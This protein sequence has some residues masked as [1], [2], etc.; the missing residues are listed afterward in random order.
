ML[1]HDL[2]K[3]YHTKTD[4]EL[5]QLAMDSEQLTLEAQAALRSELARRRID[6]AEHRKVQEERNQDRIEPP[7]TRGMLLLP[8]S[9]GVGEFVAEVL[10]VYHG[11]FLFFVKLTAPA[12]VVGYIAV[13]MGRNE[14]REIARHLPRGVEMLGHKTEI[15]EMWFANFAGYF[16]SWMAFCFS[17]GA[18]CAAV[19]QI[20]DGVIPSVRDCFA[21]IRERMSSFLQLSLLL[22]F[23]LFAIEVGA[24]LL[25]SGVFWVLHQ[26]HAHLSSFTIQFLSF[27][28]AGLGLLVFSRFGLGIPALVLGNCRVG[29][30]MFRSDELTE[31]K[32]LTLAVLLTKSLIGGYFT[33]MAPFWLASFIPANI[34]L[35]TWFPWVL[36]VASIAGV[37]VVEPTMFIGFALLYS[38]MSTLSAA[39]SELLAQQSM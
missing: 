34:E 35:P 30:A 37:T 2:A 24:V 8:D 31:G 16:V 7:R 15:L 3:E 18:I 17:F 32:W 25:Y 36:T 21:T 28:S 27:G 19:R 38:K 9:Q 12:V 29:Q 20:E 5:L 39:S 4:E 6:S 1:I 13:I 26:R 22:L 33:G 11:Q 10:R 14:G 23:A